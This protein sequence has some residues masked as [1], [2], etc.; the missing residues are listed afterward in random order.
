MKNTITLERIVIVLVL[1]FAFYQMRT[2]NVYAEKTEQI[3]SKYETKKDSLE[4][5]TERLDFY[6]DSL[7]VLKDSLLREIKAKEIEYNILQNTYK[8]EKSKN[9]YIKTNELQG[10][11]NNI[12][13]ESFVD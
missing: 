2:V 1:L 10:I 13:L 11:I 5:M 4:R 3:K 8:L 9:K 12:P 6:S 7:A